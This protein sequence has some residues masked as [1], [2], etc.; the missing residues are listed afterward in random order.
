MAD[1]VAAPSSVKELTADIV[2]AFV[3]AN[4]LPA[5]DLADLIRKVHDAL[6]TADSAPTKAA[7]EDPAPKITPA[8]IR[9]SITPDALISFLDGKPY[10]MLRRHL[11]THGHT[12]QTYREHY[13]L[14][15]N[16]PM[17]AQVHSEMRSQL[18]KRIGLGAHGKGGKPAK[19][20]PKA[21]AKRGV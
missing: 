13:G 12:P 8:M 10:K 4:P 2:A 18:A 16:Y 14:P 20:P 17:V 15:E 1:D 11:A 9:K 3:A 6:M 7:V 19:A 5:A 21:R